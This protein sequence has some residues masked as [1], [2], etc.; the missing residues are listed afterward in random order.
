MLEF[1]IGHRVVGVS[2]R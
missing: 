2:G 1:V